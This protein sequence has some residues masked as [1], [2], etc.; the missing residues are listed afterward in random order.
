[1]YTTTVRLGTRP[2]AN[3]NL[4][5]SARILNRDH[6]ELSE[7][8]EDLQADM[9]A[10]KDRGRTAPLLHKLTRFTRTHFALEEG[11]MAAAEYPG[12]AMHSVMHQMM[13]QQLRAF[14]SSYSRGR[15][16]QGV[17][18]PMFLA[19][20]HIAHTRNEDMH[21]DRWLNDDEPS[22]SNKDA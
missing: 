17:N 3:A 19:E 20:W 22:E 18:L 12:L 4:S 2:R 11:I 10:G 16:K 21:L 7:T 15:T 14:N 8:I 5:L 9:I 13:M 1:M 6:R